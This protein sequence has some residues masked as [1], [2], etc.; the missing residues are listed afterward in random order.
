MLN[1]ANYLSLLRSSRSLSACSTA[2][3]YHFIERSLYSGL[4]RPHD[5]QIL[6]LTPS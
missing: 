5:V 6:I 1:N 3:R 2:G 4:I